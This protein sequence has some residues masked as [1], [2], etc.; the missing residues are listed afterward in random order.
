MKSFKIKFH[1][2]IDL[3]TNSSTEMFMDY[4]ESVEPCKEMINEMLIAC[5][6]DKTCDDIFDIRLENEDEESTP[7]TLVITAKDKKFE[8]LVEAIHRFINS[9]VNREFMN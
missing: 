6:I 9:A 1:S 5:G 7:A 4:S 3:I 2:I 8:N